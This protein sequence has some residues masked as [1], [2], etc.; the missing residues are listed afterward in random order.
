MGGQSEE[1]EARE[2]EDPDVEDLIVDQS[3]M[4]VSP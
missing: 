3:T 1:I 4:G 2:P